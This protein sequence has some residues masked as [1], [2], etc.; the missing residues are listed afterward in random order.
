MWGSPVGSRFISITFAPA[1][2]ATRG[3][4]DA[5]VTFADVPMTRTRS[6]APAACSEGGGGGGRVEEPHSRWLK[7]LFELLTRICAEAASRQKMH[8]NHCAGAWKRTAMASRAA[9]G[10]IA[11]PNSTALGFSGCRAEVQRI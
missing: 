2:A 5:G 11:S 4:S 1:R 6:A 8:R 10:G 9:A 3:I 7:R